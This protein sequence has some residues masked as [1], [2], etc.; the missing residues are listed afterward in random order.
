[1][2]PGS[3][4]LSKT[5]SVTY[6]GTITFVFVFVFSFL[7]TFHLMTPLIVDVFFHLHEFSCLILQF[8]HIFSW[9]LIRLSVNCPGRMTETR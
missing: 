5:V 3:W 4:I 1:M 9:L 6:C 7:I 2:E 8:V